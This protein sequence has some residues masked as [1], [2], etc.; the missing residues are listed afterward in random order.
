M[1]KIIYFLLALLAISCDL[2]NETNTTSQKDEIKVL[3]AE[4]DQIYNSDHALRKLFTPDITE[5]KRKEIL[6]EFG[7]TQEEFNEQGWEIVERQ[8]SLNLLRVEEIIAKHGYPG[9]SLVG[10]PTNKSAYYVI[11]HSD[12]IE[13]YFPLIEEAGESSEIPKRLVAMM[14]DRLLVG[15]GKE[16]IYGTQINGKMVL[17]KETGKE[18]WFQFL[19]PLANPDKVNELRK[20]VGLT[21]SIEEYVTSMGLEYKLYSL[22]D[23]NRITER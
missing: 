13:K 11:Q 9:K 21:E 16:Q 17:N 20:E 19:W 7:Y 18:E 3:K 5:D 1:N 2:Q 22:E 23:I 10:E 8:D 6:T 14:H 4:L 12:K 15:Q